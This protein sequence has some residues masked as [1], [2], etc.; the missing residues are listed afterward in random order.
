MQQQGQTQTQSQSQSQSQTQ[1][2]T[3]GP[4]SPDPVRPGGEASLRRAQRHAQDSAVSRIR[5]YRDL[6]Q[7]E[8]AIKEKELYLE[9]N[10]QRDRFWDNEKSKAEQNIRE[11][12]SVSLLREVLS[13]NLAVSDLLSDQCEGKWRELAGMP[14]SASAL[15]A[16]EGAAS[17]G[18]HVLPSQS[19][20]PDSVHLDRLLGGG[21]LSLTGTDD[22]LPLSSPRPLS[23]RLNQSLNQS[24]SSVPGTPLTTRPAPPPVAKRLIDS[25]FLAG[26]RRSDILALLSGESPDLTP[27]SIYPV[28]VGRDGPGCKRGDIGKGRPSSVRGSVEGG[29]GGGNISGYSL[30]P[31]IMYLTSQDEDIV[32][33]IL[34][35]FCFPNGVETTVTDVFGGKIPASSLG[36]SIPMALSGS[37]DPQGPVETIKPKYFV[38]QLT[39]NEN[40]Q[41]GVCMRFPRRFGDKTAFSPIVYTSYC[42][43]LITANPLFL[44]LF[45]VLAAF[46]NAGGLDVSEPI[47]GNEEGMLLPSNLKYLDEFASRLLRQSVPD[48]GMQLGNSI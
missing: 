31:D 12:S 16:G 5:H 38:F 32:T 3:Q 6:Q 2:Q 35:S 14:G 11:K 47:T 24:A 22:G 18:V 43:C 39:G 34:P 33:S 30:S 15:L 9:K 19:T 46:L 8:Q 23:R 29:G 25:V 42:I 26:P 1:T 36:N 27:T 4:E 7:Y 41:Y 17:S 37:L 20:A 40:P 21:P 45:D 10:W 28:A 13:C 44:F 48:Y